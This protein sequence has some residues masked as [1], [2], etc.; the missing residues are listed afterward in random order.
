MI[1]KIPTTHFFTCGSAEGF[2]QLNSFDGAL[3]AANIGNTNL[4][5]MSSIIPP[6]NKLVEHQALPQ[7]ALVPVAYAAITSEL[8]GEVIS[9][10]VAAAYPTD[11]NHAS[12]IMEYSA[13]GHKE[14]IEAIVRRMA[15]EGL[16]MRGLEV[17]DIRSISVQHKVEKIG[18]AFAAVVLWDEE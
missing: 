4:V 14:D 3:L 2:T 10:G 13:R 9:A 18:T 5:K 6:G 17:K 16:Q 8:P 1:F 15:E 7:G 12:L 11:E